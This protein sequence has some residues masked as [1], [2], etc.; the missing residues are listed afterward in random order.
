MASALESIRKALVSASTA[1]ALTTLDIFCNSAVLVV[2][3][4]NTTGYMQFG[5]ASVDGNSGRV[6]SGDKLVINRDEVFN[7]KDI[8]VYG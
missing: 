8:Y 3:K 5:G 7:L 4:D 6:R 1:E 2:D